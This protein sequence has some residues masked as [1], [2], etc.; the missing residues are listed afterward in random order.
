MPNPGVT[1]GGV[2]EAAVNTLTRLKGE[3]TVIFGQELLRGNFI[4]KAD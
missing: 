1:H 4:I 2:L 3:G